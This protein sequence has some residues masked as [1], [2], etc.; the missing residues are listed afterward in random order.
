MREY[1]FSRA[2][3][4]REAMEG[5]MVEA[6]KRREVRLQEI[7]RKAQEEDAKVIMLYINH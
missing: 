4:H 3:E 5:R 2:V 1:Q 7:V 6:E